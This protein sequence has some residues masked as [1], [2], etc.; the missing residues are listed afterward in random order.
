M[1]T[2]GPEAADDTLHRLLAGTYPDP[3]GGAPLGVPTRRVVIAPSLE[4]DEA[5]LVR[6]LDFGSRL[7][8]VSDPDTHA[9]LGA[10]VERALAAPGPVQPVHLPRRPHADMETVNALAQEVAAADALIAVG[11]GTI[12]DLCKM[13]AA[14]SGKPYA[15]FATAPSMNGY[16]S[17]NASI[18][19]HGHKRTFPARAPVGVFIDLGVLAAA[20][21]RLIRAG[22]GDSLCRPTAQADWLLAHL[23]LGRPYREA[24]F[25][26]LAADEEALFDGAAGL[27]RGDLEVME[28]LARTLVLSG[29]GMT[30]CGGSHPASQGEHLISHYLEM[31]ADP[32]DPSDPKCPAPFHGE[33]IAV[34][35]LTM[36]RLQAAILDAPAPVVRP[37]AL[38]EGE[39]VARFGACTGRACWAEFALKRLDAA[40]AEA[41]TATLA[42][43]WDDIRAR[44]LAVTVPVPRLEAVLAAVDAPRRPRDLRWSAAAYRDALVHAREIRNR[45]TF[46]DL[47]VD[48][49]LFARMGTDAP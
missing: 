24:P 18:R 9:A 6:S 31:T 16:A 4:G 40:A 25:R 43:R 20:P 1:T 39:F 12:N 17:A 11:S 10:R 47:A 26:L 22:L 5:A 48:C 37:P 15:V 32:G 14:R 38:A 8:V 3:D 33:Q 23:L 27:L 21:A 29:F 46:L 13:V 42:A 34:T 45:Y 49:G 7:A 41:L 36:A 28:R 19:E 2:P 35:T 30:I 44:I